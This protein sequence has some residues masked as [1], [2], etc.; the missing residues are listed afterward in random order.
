MGDILKR[1]CL[2]IKNLFTGWAAPDITEALSPSTPAF[3]EDIGNAAA[4]FTDLI[5]APIHAKM[6][7]LGAT[8]SPMS[9][10]ESVK[11]ATAFA[12][13]GAVGFGLGTAGSTLSELFSLG[14]IESVSEWMRSFWV[15]AG[16]A[17]MLGVPV[18]TLYDKGVRVPFTYWANAKYQPMIPGSGDL[19]RFAVREAWRAELQEG[20][21]DFFITNMKY[22]GYKEEWAKYYWAA[23]WII[24]TYEQAR[25][26]FWRGIITETEFSDLRKYADLAP[27]YNNVWEG[28]QYLM[29]GKID[30]RWL[31]EWGMIE[32][33]DMMDLLRAGGIH[34]DWVDR[35]AEAYI[36]NQLRDEKGRVRSQLIKKYTMGAFTKSELESELSGLGFR[37]ESVEL[38]IREAELRSEN[39]DL[40]DK[41]K[42]YEGQ[43]KKYKITEEEFVA[44]LTGLG[45]RSESITIRLN[46]VLLKRKP[47]EE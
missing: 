7:E 2:A 17:G 34:P 38:M 21:P 35:V 37:A 10:E 36:R 19:V 27:A 4:A 22:H 39:E 26:A 46:A 41:I 23:H 32:K 3:R 47:K 43:L 15:Q 33:A 5:L 11:W 8:H 1:I 9:P 44:A 16:F 45:M 42:F 30:S 29:P 28:L 14:Q 40:E 31:Y 24:P 18:I 20:T 6:D 13:V 12:G 25:L